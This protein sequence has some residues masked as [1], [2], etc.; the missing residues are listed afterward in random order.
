[1]KNVS[2]VS[3]FLIFKK[4]HIKPVFEKVLSGKFL[5]RPRLCVYLV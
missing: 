1:M 3:G 4:T 2:V 5:A